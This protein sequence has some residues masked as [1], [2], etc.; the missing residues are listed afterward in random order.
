MEENKKSK[1]DEE[2][3]ENIG[4]SYIYLGHAELV[5][6]IILT[7]VCAI[8]GDIVSTISIAISGVIS[9]CCLYGIGFMKDTVSKN[10]KKIK[11]LSERLEML[12]EKSNKTFENI[13]DELHALKYKNKKEKK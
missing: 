8:Y 3:H 11:L 2:E 12:E 5:A 13:D 10:E 4:N 7:I 1:F 9:V 6:S